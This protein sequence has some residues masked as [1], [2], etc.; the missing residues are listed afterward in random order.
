MREI[1]R[2]NREK[3]LAE[4]AQTA[5]EIDSIFD[6]MDAQLNLQ[7]NKEAEVEKLMERIDKEDKL[8]NNQNQ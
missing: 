1:T 6:H 4:A 3:A 2:I 8:T 7:D 5:E